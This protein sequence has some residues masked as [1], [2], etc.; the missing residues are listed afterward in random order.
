MMRTA[1]S[2]TGIR[3][4]FS[5]LRLSNEELVVYI[6]QVVNHSILRFRLPP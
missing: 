2:V 4:A 1:T 5:Y 6:M 3:I